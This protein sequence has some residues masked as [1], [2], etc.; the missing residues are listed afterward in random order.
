MSR[1]YI[2]TG[3]FVARGPFGLRVSGKYTA[4]VPSA[5]SENDARDIVNN[6]LTLTGKRI[7]S[8]ID[9]DTVEALP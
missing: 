9:I 4:T 1:D 3:T 8:Q 2:V 7:T 5:I 6:E